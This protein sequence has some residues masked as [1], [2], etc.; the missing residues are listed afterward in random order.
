MTGQ[1]TINEHGEWTRQS[2]GRRVGIPSP[3][4]QAER[5][6]KF[7][8]H[9]LQDN[10]D[11]LLS[12]ILGFRKQFGTLRT[13]VLVAISD[14]G[15]IER[16]R[17]LELAEVC[18]ADQV[19]ERIHGIMKRLRSA[20]SIL[21]LSLKDA[22]LDLGAGEMER[23]SQFFLS[24]HRPLRVPVPTPAVPVAQ[25]VQ[26][27]ASTARVGAETVFRCR[28]CDSS[29]VAIQYARSYYFKCQACGGNTP[30]KATCEACGGSA[31]LRK[32]G[33]QFDAECGACGQRRHFFT[34]PRGSEDPR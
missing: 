21:S 20:N 24:W 19:P 33:L 23:I 32:S 14:S 27:T 15:I 28:S 11:Q 29:Q 13:D 2:A 5:Q 1:V 22:A 9:L 31:K 4:L 26:H 18:K 25:P 8:R 7:L 16:P 3:I 30:A 34:N 10:V 12:R 6:A 17:A